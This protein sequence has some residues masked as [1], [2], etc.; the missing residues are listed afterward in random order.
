[1]IKG[2]LSGP[3]PLTLITRAISHYKAD[4]AAFIEQHQAIVLNEKTNPVEQESTLGD[5]DDKFEKLTQRVTNLEQKLA[6]ALSK[7]E[8]L[9]TAL[10]QGK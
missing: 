4:P 2:N 10:E 8:H 3:A 6:S 9:E 7:I 1:M 5:N